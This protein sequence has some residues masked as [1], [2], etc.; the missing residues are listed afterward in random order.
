MFTF[1][2]SFFPTQFIVLFSGNINYYLGS[3]GNPIT[4]SHLLLQL[5]TF[6]NDD[7]RG[8]VVAANYIQT[9][10]REWAAQV[11]LPPAKITLHDTVIAKK[12]HGTLSLL[13][14][15]ERMLGAAPLSGIIP[16]T[17]IPA[18]SPLETGCCG[19]HWQN[20]H[21]TGRILSGLFLSASYSM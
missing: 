15:Q 4:F 16:V 13:H 3:K 5:K 10:I 20:I 19:K 12:H 9:V 1:R 21:P 11:S 17:C 14:G 18:E 2:Y 7:T 8:S 6:T